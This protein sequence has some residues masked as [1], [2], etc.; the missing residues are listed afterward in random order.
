MIG[1]AVRA[2]LIRQDHLVRSLTRNDAGDYRWDARPGSVPPEA[3]T[4]ADAVVSLNGVSLTHLPWTPAYRGRIESSRVE[5]TS[6][7]AQAIRAA[8]SPPQVWLSGSAVG[9]YGNR[10][11]E[12]LDETSSAADTFL[13]R[14]VRAWE[15]ATESA[16]GVTRVVCARTGIVLGRD[17]ALKPLALATRWGLGARIGRG[18][19]WWPWISLD[20]E[21]R[22]IVFALTAPAIAGPVD[23]VGPE[24]ATAEDISRALARLLRRP[25]WLVLPTPVIKA[26]MRGADDLL[27]SSQRVHPAVLL[28][29]GFT[30]HHTSAEAAIAYVCGATA[31]P[32]VVVRPTRRLAG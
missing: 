6:A 15:A 18:T 23:L 22:A 27:L 14:V 29:A 8:A 30:F 25:H 12:E 19:Q 1:T 11:D 10:G 2:E 7:L 17:G 5:A 20:D 3:L 16:R 32:P 24:P 28:K 31:P 26:V 4:W 21:A 13:A 9:I